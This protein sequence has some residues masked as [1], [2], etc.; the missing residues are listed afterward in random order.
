MRIMMVDPE[1]G[2]SEPEG[3]GLRILNIKDP[4]SEIVVQVPL[5]LEACTQV[6]QRLEGRSLVVPGP[7]A[8]SPPPE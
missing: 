2:V 4:L 8:P 3:A 1:I 6:A 5:D 7:V